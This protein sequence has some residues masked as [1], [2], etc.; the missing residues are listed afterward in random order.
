MNKRE[1]AIYL[2]GF[3]DGEGYIGLLKRIKRKKYLEYFVQI[4][5]GQNDGATL[6]WIKDNFGG[7]CYLIKRDNSFYWSASNRAAYTILKEIYPFL[8][9]KK[10]QAE[11]AIKYFEEQL[12][13]KQALSDNEMDR[14]EEIYIEL[15]RLKKVFTKSSY[16]NNMQVQR[17]NEPDSIKSM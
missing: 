7:N 2:A 6:D 10:P 12:P 14:R 16:C 11:L 9:Y 15:K 13:R 5:I 4:A 1:R 8:R 17:L 3:F